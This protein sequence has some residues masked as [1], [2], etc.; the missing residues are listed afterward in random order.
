[1]TRG[2]DTRRNGGVADR[3]YRGSMILM[4]VGENRSGVKKSCEAAGEI[5]TKPVQIVGAHLVDNQDDHELRWL[6]PD[7]CSTG[8]QT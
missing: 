3:R 4:C 2:K 5:P 7:L 6:V 1:M 8:G